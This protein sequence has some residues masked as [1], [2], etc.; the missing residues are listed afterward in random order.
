MPAPIEAEHREG[1][2]GKGRWV[3]PEEL[4]SLMPLK[5]SY[6][7]H[8]Y[9]KSCEKWRCASRFDERDVWRF[10]KSKVLIWYM[11]RNAVSGEHYPRTV[12]RPDDPPNIIRQRKSLRK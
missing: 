5:L 12:E 11:P 7:R 6:I 8:L 4:T 3:T 2:G 10:S 1:P 9:S